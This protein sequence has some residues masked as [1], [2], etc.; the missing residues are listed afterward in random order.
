[1][2]ED[3]RSESGAGFFFSIIFVRF[4]KYRH[5]PKKNLYIVYSFL[6]APSITARSIDISIDGKDTEY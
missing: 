3:S 1:M 2:E 5:I 6:V 4:Q